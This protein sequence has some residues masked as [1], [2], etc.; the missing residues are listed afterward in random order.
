MVAFSFHQ[1]VPSANNEHNLVNGASVDGLLPNCKNWGCKWDADEVEIE[2]KE[3][4]RCLI[5]CNTAWSPPLAW[6]AKM[7]GVFPKLT[8]TVAYCEMGMGFYGLWRRCVATKL[9]KE[10]EYQFVET[11]MELGLENDDAE[12][13]MVPIGPGGR[14]KQFMEEHKIRDMG[15]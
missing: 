10:E 12:A 4:K 9:K 15:G 3:P 1:V 8:V 6:A 2:T 14:L 11:D 7:C 13:E 5:Q